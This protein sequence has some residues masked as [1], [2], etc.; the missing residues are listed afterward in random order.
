MSEPKG[1]EDATDAILEATARL[2]AAPGRC[3]GE[4]RAGDGCPEELTEAVAAELREHR[5]GLADAMDD[6]PAGGYFEELQSAMRAAA[7]VGRSLLGSVDGRSAWG[8]DPAESPLPPVRTEPVQVDPRP[9]R[10]RVHG[11]TYH[12][13]RVVHGQILGCS[14]VNRSP[15]TILPP[16]LSLPSYYISIT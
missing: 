8:L 2:V 9:V 5:V 14:E 1:L 4:S 11:K 16:A 3:E 10:V 13:H 7:M 12:L 6:V 15:G